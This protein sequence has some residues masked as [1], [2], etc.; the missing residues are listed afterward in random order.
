[1]RCI[2]CVAL[3]NAKRPLPRNAR[4]APGFSLFQIAIKRSGRTGSVVNSVVKSAGCRDTERGRSIKCERVLPTE[5]EARF[6]HLCFNNHRRPQR[7]GMS[8]SLRSRYTDGR[9]C[10]D[11]GNLV[12][13]WWTN[14]AGRNEF[15]ICADR[16]DT[17]RRT[18]TD[19]ADSFKVNSA[20]GS[21]RD[22]WFRSV[23]PPFEWTNVH[24]DGL[25][26]NYTWIKR[27]RRGRWCAMNSKGG[28]IDG[29]NFNVSGSRQTPAAWCFARPIIE[30]S[31]I[32]KFAWSTSISGELWREI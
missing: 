26:W 30:A 6:N 25:L 17:A 2:W 24:R 31:M 13:S 18:I 16:I 32:S 27:R 29:Y 21:T 12:P 7:W 5:N 19:S 23:S 28:P 14:Y 9:S 1:M 11:R 22:T 15:L 10:R 20:G 4:A 8:S 3:W